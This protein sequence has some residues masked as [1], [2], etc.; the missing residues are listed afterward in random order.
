MV[1]VPMSNDDLVGDRGFV[2]RWN[3]NINIPWNQTYAAR[4][5]WFEWNTQHGEARGN[6]SQFKHQIWVV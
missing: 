5:T 1:N 2:K 4:P 3:D 6:H